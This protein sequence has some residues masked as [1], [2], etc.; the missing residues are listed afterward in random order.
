MRC[1]HVAMTK[2]FFIAE[3]A[4]RTK[5]FKIC[6][7]LIFFWI[8]VQFY[9]LN[10]I[11]FHFDHN[12]DECRLLLENYLLF[13]CFKSKKNRYLHC[14]V[15][16]QLRKLGCALT[17]FENAVMQ[18]QNCVAFQLNQKVYSGSCAAFQKLKT[19]NC[20]FKIDKIV[21]L[22]WHCA[23]HIMFFVP[24]SGIIL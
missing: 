5:V 22:F 10:L 24:I 1:R 2:F 11:L 19:L 7:A 17:W 9:T 6:C 23:F 3:V 20:A 14:S 15:K 8:E 18:L 16:F 21:V 12:I 13:F 4:W